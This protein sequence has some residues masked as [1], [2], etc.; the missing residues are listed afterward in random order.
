MLTGEYVYHQCHAQFEVPVPCSPTEEKEAK[1]PD[2]GNM[3]VERLNV[4]TVETGPPP[5]EYVCH[6]C[7][8]QFEVPVPRGPDEAKE[9]KCRQCGGMDIER[10]NVCTLE[11]IDHPCG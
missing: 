10:L 11:S 3:D 4:C 8:A 5:W 7:H 9:I 1:C 6:Q 2:C